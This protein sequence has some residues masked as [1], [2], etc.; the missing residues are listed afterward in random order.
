MSSGN[1]P[2]SRFT[3]WYTTVLN[4]KAFLAFAEA[5]CSPAFSAVTTIS[6]PYGY[7]AGDPAMTATFHTRR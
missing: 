5:T 2:L 1:E 7:F 4:L 3:V 6:T